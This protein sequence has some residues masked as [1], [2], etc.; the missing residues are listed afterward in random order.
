METKVCYTCGI[1]KELS[2]FHK[3]KPHKQGVRPNCKVCRK[4]QVGN[5]TKPQHTCIRCKKSKDIVE[6]LYDTLASGVSM[7]C[8]ECRPPHRSST[9]KV[10]MPGTRPSGEGSIYGTEYW[11][12]LAQEQ[13]N[14]IDT[15]MRRDELREYL[16]REK[17]G[18]CTLC[19]VSIDDIPALCFDFHHEDPSKKDSTIARLIPNAIYSGKKYNE[20][21]VELEKCVILCASCHRQEH[22]VLLRTQR[23]MHRWGTNGSQVSS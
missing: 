20:L 1:E 14:S 12:S 22:S 5:R 15:A 21:V 7:I 2:E 8:S 4:I 17:G 16:I 23:E 18:K 10:W 19:G 9:K 13:K 6:F 11:D 3:S